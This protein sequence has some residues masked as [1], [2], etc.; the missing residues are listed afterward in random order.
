MHECTAIGV[1][2]PQQHGLGAGGN[3]GVGIDQCVASAVMQGRGVLQQTPQALLDAV[4][5][6]AADQR[7]HPHSLVAR[8]AY[9]DFGQLCTD[10]LGHTVVQRLRYQHAAYGRAFLAGF[11]RHFAHHFTRQQG[12]GFAVHAMAGQQQR[13]VHA[14]GFDIAAH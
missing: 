7:P 9:G 13:A 2:C 11:D 5:L 3:R 14:V 1:L 12:S 6:L 8:V 10:G 4:V